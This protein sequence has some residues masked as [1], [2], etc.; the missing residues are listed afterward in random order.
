MAKRPTRRI[1]PVFA[2][3]TFLDP[4]LVAQLHVHC[5]ATRERAGDVIADALALH[6][7]G[8]ADPVDASDLV[9]LV[10]AGDHVLAQL[11]LPL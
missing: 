3:L 4:R 9:G 2:F 11:A 8:L 7:D 6:L 10:D 5:A 1:D